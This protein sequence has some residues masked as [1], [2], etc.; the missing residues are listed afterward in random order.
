MSRIA[1][2]ALLL[3]AGCSESF[4]EPEEAAYSDRM[5][6]HFQEAAT[7]YNVPRD[8]LVALSWT[9]SRLEHEVGLH[10]HGNAAHGMMGLLEDSD[11]GPSLDGAAQRIGA[12]PDVLMA[13]ARLNILGA[14]A[15]LSA[16][17]TVWSA[18]NDQPVETLEDWAHVI[19]WYSGVEHSGM[20][21]SFGEEVFSVIGRGL[22]HTLPSGELIVIEGRPLD[23]PAY[24]L[25]PVGSVASDYWGSANFV[26]AHSGNYTNA[27]R[28]TSDIDTVVVHTAQGSYSGTANWFANSSASASAHYVIRSSDGEVTQMVWEEDVAWHAGHSSTNWS[29]I[30]IEQE[31][32][33][34]S[35][36]TCLLY[37]SPSPRDDR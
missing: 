28:S 20:Q 6:D 29:S 36:G 15:E 16:Y 30:G 3:T 24:R 9:V 10:D 35:P 1:L 25:M 26:A 18:E 19:G 5:D 11:L 37:T 27:S 2:T 14:A 22:S 8:L 32:Y 23:I 33:I 7:R 34:E 17:A 31:G 12:S 21:R 4:S 13:D